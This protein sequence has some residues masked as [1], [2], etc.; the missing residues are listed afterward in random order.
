MIAHSFKTKNLS[1]VTGKLTVAIDK[2]TGSV[3]FQQRLFVIKNTDNK[4]PLEHCEILRETDKY[5]YI[6]RLVHLHRETFGTA[7]FK[8]SDLI[9]RTDL[10]NK[11]PDNF[12]R[13]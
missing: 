4:D 13:L 3:V 6:E 11:F 9:G 10:M 12:Q 2:E 5:V 8:L 1:G 7:L